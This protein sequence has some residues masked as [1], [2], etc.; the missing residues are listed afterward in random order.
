MKFLKTLRNYLCYCGIEK[1][2]YRALKKDAYVANFQVWRVLH[3]LMAVVFA[4]LFIGSFSL[5]VLRPNMY[6]YLSEFLYAVIAACLF[7]FVFKKD[8]LIAQLVIYL[9]VSLLFLF[10]AMITQNKPDLPA[11]TFIVFLIIAPMFIIDKPYFMGI[12]LTAASVIFLFWM[13]GVK[14]PDA[15][16]MDVANLIVYV[17]VGFIIHV[18]LNSIRIKEFVLA[19]EIRLQKDLDDITGLKNKGALTREINEYLADPWK[20]KGIMFLLDIDHFKS[21]NDTY[22]HDVGDDVIH[23]LGVLLKEL[24]TGDEIAGRFGGDEFILLLKDTDDPEA[25]L[26]AAHRI[27]GGAAEKIVLP[28]KSKKITVSM[29]IAV[30]RGKE[31]NYSEIFKKADIALYKVKSDRATLY[32]FYS[33]PDTSAEAES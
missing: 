21:V 10:G 22:G 17:I 7:L 1:E 26:E 20:T 11:T 9:S 13:H 2:E 18:I 5:E 33:E 24:F 6:F 16:K 19:R 31:K 32:E 27:I 30:Y 25:A 4:A 29:G 28:D 15:W 3:C 23:Q 8:S 14:S 12:E